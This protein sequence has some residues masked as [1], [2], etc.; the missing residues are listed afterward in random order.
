[1]RQIQRDVKKVRSTKLTRVRL[2]CLLSPVRS[3]RFSIFDGTVLGFLHQEF[4]S[5]WP[6][7]HLDGKTVR[8]W[9]T[10][11]GHDGTSLLGHTKQYVQVENSHGV[12][13]LKTTFV[14][15]E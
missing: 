11:K 15:I 6:Y 8:V 9:I 4:E 2:F 10:D 7:Q 13:V 5:F 14:T 12:C 3:N 1:M